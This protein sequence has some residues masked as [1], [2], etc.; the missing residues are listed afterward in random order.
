MQVREDITLIRLDSR[1]SKVPAKEVTPKFLIIN[2][3]ERV[4]RR[5]S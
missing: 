5:M 2:S 4:C 1:F 3:T